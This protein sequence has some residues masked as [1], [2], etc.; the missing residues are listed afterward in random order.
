MIRNQDSPNIFH[1]FSELINA[2]SMIY[3]FNLEPEEIQIVFLESMTFN[4]EP[5]YDIYRNI[6]SRGNEPIYIKN[7][8]KRYHI[9]SAINVPISYDSPLYLK[10]ICPNCKY[11]TKTYKIANYLIN[12]YMN[13]SEF[14]DLFISDNETFYYPEKV[15]KNH[16]LNILLEFMELD[17]HY[18]FSCHNNQYFKKFFLIKKINYFY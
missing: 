3:L 11:S 12:K 8:N 6:I 13:I 1:G 7:L 16:E 4:E 9:A 2:L 10:I 15:I 17:F 5:F 18:Q 14:N